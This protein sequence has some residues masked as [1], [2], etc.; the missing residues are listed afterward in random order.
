MLC[1]VQ[2]DDVPSAHAKDRPSRLEKI[3]YTSV[4]IMPFLSTYSAAYQTA[5]N[6]IVLKVNCRVA[7]APIARYNT[8]AG[9]PLY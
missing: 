2:H 6:T 7:A 1:Q 4:E 5:S 3:F 9:K 8:F